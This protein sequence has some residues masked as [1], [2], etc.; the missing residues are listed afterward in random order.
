MTDWSESYHILGAQ[1][2]PDHQSVGSVNECQRG[3]VLENSSKNMNDINWFYHSDPQSVTGVKSVKSV[4][5][6]IALKE[7]SRLALAFSI[8]ELRCPDL[9]S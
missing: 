8:I 6:V 4:N 2:G 5:G 7:S 1:T 3:G 9:V